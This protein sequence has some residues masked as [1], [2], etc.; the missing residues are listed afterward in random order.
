MKKTIFL[1]F[2]AILCAIGMNAATPTK[3]YLNAQNWG[4]SDARYAAYFFDPAKWV[5]MKKVD[6]ETFIYEVDVPAGYTKV[7]MCR[8]NGGT[9]ENNWDNKWNQTGDLTIPTDGKNMFKPD[10]WNGKTTT[11]STYTPTVTH[12]FPSG[13]TLYLDFTAVATKGADIPSANKA[14]TVYDANAGGSVIPVTFTVDVKWTEG[15]KFLKTAQSGW[16]NDIPFKAP[17]EGENCAKVAADGKSYTWTTYTESETPDPT[18][19]P[20][21]VA[22]V[23]IYFVNTKSWSSVNAYVWGT[24]PYKAW[25][26]EAMTSTG[27]KAHGYDVYSYTFPETYTNCIFNGNG[28]TDDLIVN[29]GQYYDIASE[30]WYATLADVPNPTPAV[31]E[32]VYFINTGNWEKVYAYAWTSSNNG[33]P[34]Q[35][36]EQNGEK[37]AEYDVYSFTAEQGQWANIIFNN[38]GGTQTGDLKWEA[39][40]YYMY[41]TN[42]W[43]DTKGDAEAALAGPATVVLH[44]NFLGSSWADTEA[45]TLSSDNKTATLTTLVKAGNH[46]FG[47]KLNNVWTS[48]GKAFTK[49]NNEHKI[50]AGSGN[51]TLNAEITGDYTFTWT[52]ETNTLTVTYPTEEVVVE[53][54]Y[55]LI[56]TFNEWTQKDANYELALVDGLYKKEVTFAKDVEFKINVGDWTS[57]W[58]KDNL[59][60]KTYAELDGTNDGNLKMKEEKTFTVIFDPANNLITFTGLTEAAPA[61]TKYYIAGTENL[62]GFN[63]QVDGLEMIEDAGVYKHTFSA[64]P[65]GTFEFKVTQ[66]DWNKE[67]WGYYQLGAAYEEVSQGKDEHGNDNGNIKFVTEEAKNIT[68]IFDATA[69]KITID[70]LT[71][72]TP[73]VITYVLMGVNGDWTNGI[74]LTQNPGNADE[75]VLENQ[76]IIKATDAVK[77][78]TL[79]DGTATAWCGNVD[80]WSNAT[81]TADGDGNIVLE[82]GIYTFYFKKNDDLIY[83]NQTGYARNV[84][85]KYGTICLPYA[86]ASTTGATFY[87]VAGKETGK[88]YLE[89]VNAL[90][91]GVPYIFEKSASQIKVVYTGD[92]ETTAGSANGLIGNFT[93]ETVVPTGNYILYSNKFIPADGTTNKVNAYRAYLN[94]SAVQG[95]APNQMPGRRYIGMDV[96]GENE[97]TG[98][99]NIVAPEGQTIKAIVNGQLVIIRGGEMYNVQGQKL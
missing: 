5:D 37:I 31:M 23:T 56:G 28:Q 38:N 71:E 66:G 62:T 14:E 96:Q 85:N 94:L 3:I 15:A 19:D 91:A 80:T 64:L 53:E 26:G 42:K 75:Y 40:K 41:S 27:D 17:A 50:E 39:G 1:F 89:S 35:Q 43:Y 74:A 21:P 8:M 22:D 51:L 16:S 18:P 9:T 93:D 59:G 20:D 54:H 73:A 7:I 78:V 97:A 82:D 68:V 83:I 95:G 36:L 61:E 6:G 30:T 52:Y 24:D 58:G 70:G 45:F 60:G 87:R 92:K 63:W 77:V 2:A 34:G 98:F 29:A 44:G 13:S 55:Y 49:T 90:E 88:V 76:V 46:E 79:T 72:K 86:S 84:T 65:A 67:S 57:S 12:T 47:V 99:E 81:Y 10:D 4:Y 33:W 11:W 32:T 48:N 25:P 69:G